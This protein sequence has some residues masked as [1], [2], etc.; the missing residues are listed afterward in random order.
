LGEPIFMVKPG[1]T[2]TLFF[3]DGF[4]GQIGAGHYK[5]WFEKLHARG[6]NIVSPITGLQGW[7]FAFRTRQWHREEDM[8]Q[9]V[10]IYDAYCANLP[11]GH[12]IIIGSMSFGALSNV[13]IGAK[14]K[15]KPDAMV[16]VSPLNTGLDYRSGSAVVRYLS[17]RI[18]IM[19]YIIP[20]MMR[21]NPRNAV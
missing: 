3:I 16:F 5:P 6:I 10:Q 4:R 13:T 20:Y 19:Q 18:D 12:K 8:R 7:P 15:R 9:A 14:G 21:G 2:T 11:K 1:N 17:S